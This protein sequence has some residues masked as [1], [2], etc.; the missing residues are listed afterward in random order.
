M[1]YKAAFLFDI[2][3][4]LILDGG[5][6]R[7][8]FKKA[9][10]EV[11][12]Q[13]LNEEGLLTSGRTDYLIARD[14]YRNTINKEPTESQILDL[15][16]HYLSNL[17]PELTESKKF[18]ILSGVLDALQNLSEDSSILLGLQTGNTRTGAGHKLNR[19]EL[20]DFFKVGGFCEG[21]DNRDLVVQSAIKSVSKL[22]PQVS[23]KTIFIIGDTPSDIKS[24]QNSGA[25]AIGVA[26]GN[27][28][29]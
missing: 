14:A 10:L 28:F 22:A 1:T 2:D 8:A 5:A 3:G 29:N 18:K 11:F 20:N 17:V 13:P 4:T 15:Q 21:F 9:F 26:T 16:D 6:A 24:A 25:V 19:A 12:N 27:F 23:P 7:Q